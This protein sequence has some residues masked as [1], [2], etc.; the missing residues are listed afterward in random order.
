MAEYILRSDASD[1]IFHYS[2]YKS[3]LKYN[4]VREKIKNK[5]MIFIL[6]SLFISPF[7]FLIFIFQLFELIWKELINEYFYSK[8]RYDKY[9][10]IMQPKSATSV[11]TIIGYKVFDEELEEHLGLVGDRGDD[12]PDKMGDKQKIMMK[13]ENKYR[14]VGFDKKILV[15]HLLMPGKTGSGKTEAI[16]SIA[17]DALRL[18]GGFL[19]ND[20]KSDE[21]M[22]TEFQTQAKKAGRETSCYVL[23]FL[24]AEKI[25][26]SNTF[27]P[28]GIMHPVKI[29]EFFGSLIGGGGNDGNAKY[30]FNRGKAML[31]PIVNAT[32]IRDKYFGEGFSIEKIFD[33]T[34]VIN[35]SILY[36]S[37][38]CMSRDINENI[39]NSPKLSVA[40]TSITSIVSD[41]DFTEIE[42]TID[43]ITQ[44][45]TQKD[46]VRESGVTFV[47]IKEV[48]SNSYLLIRGYMEK[49]WNQFGPFLLNIS[50]I[51]Y[52]MSKQDGYYFF[53]EGAMSITDIKKQFVVIK[54]IMVKRDE[55]IAAEFKKRYHLNSIEMNTLVESFNGNKGTIE[56]PPPDAI[57]QH[58]YAQQQFS[59][60]EAIFTTYKHIFGQNKPEIK[61][62]KLIRDNKFL[63]IVLP[64]LEVQPDQVEILGKMIIMTIREVAA[65]ALGGEKL[66]QHKTIGAIN[67]DKVTPKPFTF[68]VLD[69]YGAYP[70][71]GIDTLLA[72]VRSLNMSMAIAVQDYA[73]LKAGGNN[74]TSQ[75]RALANTTKLILKMEDDKAIEWVNRMMVDTNQEVIKY[76]RSAYGNMVAKHDVEIDKKKLFD[77]AKLRDFDNGFS[78]L[79]TGSGIEGITYLQTFYRGGETENI[80][81][82]RYVPFE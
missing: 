43:Y 9:S 62:D 30:F 18:G 8:R 22:F 51:I 81:I 78:L 60:L 49:V 36:I 82:K 42:K 59:V 45:P 31:F 46:I 67:K 58:S 3:I 56:N 10:K 69:E 20:G 28:L 34:S 61:P 13:P 41:L 11:L 38:Y 7:F 57:Q 14:W 24:K 75:E 64:P 80:M 6:P 65:I 68:V 21:K 44:N 55:A 52:K 63:Y 66:S 74:E 50:K 53:G 23:N 15:T 25:A 17:D 70:V 2:H 77:A 72:Q 47:E 4:I 54:E 26:E 5:I 12:G 71:D 19:F 37:L 1:Y 76:D 39:K 79:L 16:R 35:I 48:Y 27:S 33:N 29:V 32:Y 73:S 40:I